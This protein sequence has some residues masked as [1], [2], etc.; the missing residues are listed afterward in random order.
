MI[1]KITKILIA[2]S[3]VFALAMTNSYSANA[4]EVNFEGETDL[5]PNP[6]TIHEDAGLLSE[7]DNIGDKLQG[8]KPETDD[9]VYRWG[10]DVYRWL[11][12]IRYLNTKYSSSVSS[13]SITHEIDSTALKVMT[14]KKYGTVPTIDFNSI[15]SVLTSLQKEIKGEKPYSSLRD[16]KD[17]TILNQIKS[18]KSLSDLRENDE[19]TTE[20]ETY[21]NDYYQKGQGYENGES[22]KDY[23]DWINNIRKLNKKYPKSSVYTYLENV[24]NPDNTNSAYNLGPEI[25]YDEIFGALN[26]LWDQTHYDFAHVTSNV[27]DSIEIKQQPSVTTYTDGDT[28]KSSGLVIDGTYKQTW[29][30]GRDPT[31]YTKN[32]MAFT[33]DTSTKLT[34]FDKD[35][36]HITSWPVTVNDGVTSK[37][38]NVP[39]TVERKLN[40]TELTSIE[41]TSQPKKT[42][43]KEGENFDTTGLSVT[44][45]F[46]RSYSDKT[47]DTYTQPDMS[48]TVVNGSSLKSTQNSV[49]IRVSSNGIQKSKE[50]PITVNKY[51]KS[52]SIDSLV[53]DSLPEKVNYM[54]GETVSTK[55]LKVNAV[56]KKTMSDGTTEYETKK[57]VPVTTT[58]P[59]STAKTDGKSITVVYNYDENGFTDS[60]KTT[61]SINV[62]KKE[63]SSTN[64]T[65]V[66]VAS[67]P[68]KTVYKEGESFDSTGLSLTGTFTN[69]YNDNT[70]TTYTQPNMSFTVVDGSSLKSTQTSVKVRVTSNNVQRTVEIP[71]T[72]KKY[73]K[74][75]TIDSLV[76]TSSPNKVKYNA[77]QK[78]TTKGLKVNAVIKKT[79]SDGTTEY[80]TKKNIKVSTSYPYAVAQVGSNTITVMYNYNE[81]GFSDTA[82]T[83]ITIEVTAKDTHLVNVSTPSKVKLKSV[84]AGKKKL[85]VKWKKAKYAKKYRVYYRIKGKKK[86][87]SKTVK[88][89][90]LVIKKLKSKKKYQVRVRAINLTAYGKY[91]KTKTV[92]VK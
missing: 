73:V 91:S 6:S 5:F 16:A 50:V 24:T 53:I 21:F 36:N 8:E 81:N 47:Q 1:G 55:G 14:N 12:D 20:D 45:T 29:S 13:K 22:T 58:Y 90:T 75:A 70:Q 80:E 15:S 83:T 46:T 89:T 62:T 37:T 72:V 35:G 25:Y 31:T 41:I 57:D 28:F 26:S 54:E 76:I 88:K 11:F 23:K 63:V 84:K 60:K 49:E 61:V 30:A 32:N 3:M 17:Q 69:T 79:M 9:E 65:S 7:L 71:I 68:S 48:Y 33:T 18:G 42:E 27:L 66:T 82:K 38:V 59:Y 64:F 78:I 56:I 86:W 77:G 74:S 39:I 19:M 51:I 67:Q 40:S 10:V 43:Y 2:F 34:Y 44:G 4:A 52:A 87:K 92:K 85:T